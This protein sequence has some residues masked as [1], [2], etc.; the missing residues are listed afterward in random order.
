[1]EIKVSPELET[2]LG[3]ARD[4]AMRT[5]HYGI[6]A[7]HLMLGILRHSDNEACRTLQAL[8]VDLRAFKRKIDD[9]VFREEAVPYSDEDKMGLTKSAHSA[10]NLTVYESLKCART[11][12]GPE[13]L[14]LALTRSE[15]TAT[16]AIFESLGIDREVLAAR[17]RTMGLL[18]PMPDPILPKAEEIARALEEEL[19]RVIN[20]IPLHKTDFYS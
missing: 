20:I 8:G 7:D 12:A 5:G 2:I 17:M 15:R 10:L 3:Y 6:G 9:A 18:K 11:A 14:L 4:E 1:M 19:R 13:H 16:V